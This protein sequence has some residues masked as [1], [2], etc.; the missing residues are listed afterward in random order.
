MPKLKTWQWVLI[1]I[2]IVG[3]IAWAM[4]AN[5]KEEVIVVTP[6]SAPAGSNLATL[7]NAIFPFFEKATDKIPAKT[8]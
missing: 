3:L 1:V 8:G 6:G 7:L 2:V 5:K 4:M